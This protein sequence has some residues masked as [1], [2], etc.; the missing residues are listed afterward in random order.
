M[1]DVHKKFASIASIQTPLSSQAQEMPEGFN[2]GVVE[3]D[4]E[5]IPESLEAQSRIRRNHSAIQQRLNF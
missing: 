5:T 3:F 1:T 2:F 4:Y